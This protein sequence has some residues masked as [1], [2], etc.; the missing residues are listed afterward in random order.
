VYLF[1][2][3]GSLR[4]PYCPFFFCVFISNFSAKESVSA[5]ESEADKD[6]SRKHHKRRRRRSRSHSPE[7]ASE[8]DDGKRRKRKHKHK[9]KQRKDEE[10]SS[11]HPGKVEVPAVERKE[12]E[13]E[14]DARLE[15]EENERLAAARKR[16]LERLSRQEQEASSINGVRLK[17]TRF[18][19]YVRSS[20]L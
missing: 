18:I 13:E 2:F 16:E 8:S 6:R 5:S 15:R 4:P 17:G 10:H 9:H 7:D 3:A 1:G 19:P 11:R 20:R 14:Y 12:T